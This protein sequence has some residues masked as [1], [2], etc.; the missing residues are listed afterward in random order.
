MLVFGTRPE[1]VKMCP[2]A[3]ALKKYKEIDLKI[4]LTGQHKELCPRVLDSFETDYNFDLD[5]MEKGQ[6]LPELLCRISE[7]LLPVLTAEKPELVLVHGDTASAF[8]AAHTCFFHGIP[9]GHVEAGLR[10]GDP[11]YPFPEEFFRCGIDMISSLCFAPSEKE[12]SN[13]I[14]EGTDKN[15]IFVVGNTVADALLRFPGGKSEGFFPDGTEIPVTLT[16]HRRETINSGRLYDIL[17]EIRETV[18]SVKGCFAVFPVHPN[19]LLKQ[20][21][22]SV[23]DGCNQVRLI[24]PLS[25]DS[26]HSL[27]CSSKLV[28]TDSGGVQEEAALLKVPAVILRKRTERPLLFAVLSGLEKGKIKEAVLPLLL[29]GGSAVFEATDSGILKD[30]RT[31]E[32]IARIVCDYLAAALPVSAG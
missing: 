7:R 12:K 20:A 16:L 28:L 18:E 31:S 3:L 29:N 30:G 2:L 11:L 6:T 13:L 27:L 8:A 1:A 17:Y 14:F 32:R 10:T 26:F 25:V 24:P 15:K 9:I 22:E 19:P 23:F 21:A 4:C 5:V